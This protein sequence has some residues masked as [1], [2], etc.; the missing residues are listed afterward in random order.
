MEVARTAVTKA[1]YLL[2]IFFMWSKDYKS[3][4]TLKATT[5]P[6]PTVVI[7]SGVQPNS[8]YAVIFLRFGLVTVLIGPI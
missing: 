4:N 3:R 6:A 5:M 1:M 8:W 7:R 2:R